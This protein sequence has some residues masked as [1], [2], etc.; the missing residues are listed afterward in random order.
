MESWTGLGSLTVITLLPTPT[1]ESWLMTVQRMLFWRSLQNQY[2]REQI[3]I[4][5]KPRKRSP[6]VSFPQDSSAQQA[7]HIHHVPS[8]SSCSGAATYGSNAQS[9]HISNELEH[10]WEFTKVVVIALLLQV[11]CSHLNEES[12]WTFLSWLQVWGGKW[13]FVPRGQETKVLLNKLYTLSSLKVT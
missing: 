5:C 11:C 3:A 13:Q 7:G 4:G 1:Q 10:L 9:F 2:F 12:V 6:R 8:R